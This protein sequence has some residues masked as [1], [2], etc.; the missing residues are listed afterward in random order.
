MNLN[1]NIKTA[2]KSYLFLS[3]VFCTFL[4][5][6]ACNDKEEPETCSLA[7][8][9]VMRNE[10]R[11]YYLE[12]DNNKKILLKDSTVIQY[13]KSKEHDR[14]LASLC[15]LN[16]QEPGYDYVAKMYDLYKVLVKP[17]LTLTPEMADSIGND[18]IDLTEMWVSKQY[19]NI[20]FR[21]LASGAGIQH[22]I[23]LA[24]VPSAGPL[25][26]EHGYVCLEFFHNRMEDTPV[27]FNKGIASF[28]LDIPGLDYKGIKIRVNTIEKGFQ[29]YTLNL[30]GGENRVRF[31]TPEG[32]LTFQS[33]I[34]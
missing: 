29:I 3:V 17:I 7:M 13:Y 4:V 28:P 24:Y 20:Q 31:S 23:N 12:M 25:V 11:N 30:T 34:L 1:L 8:A 22:M 19:I 18:K 10:S 9:T 33:D 6:L 5:I 27:K 32:H 26:D 14:I 2:R 21:Y 15:L 16:E